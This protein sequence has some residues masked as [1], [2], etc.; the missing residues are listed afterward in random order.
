LPGII[1]FIVE[2]NFKNNENENGHSN[3]THN[4]L[5]NNDVYGF[6]YKVGIISFCLIFIIMVI[7]YFISTNYSFYLSQFAVENE[8]LI[9]LAIATSSIA[10]GFISLFYKFLKKFL[11]FEL[12]FILA[13]LFL[14]SGYTCISL[15][16]TFYI[17]VLGS[18]IM[19]LGWGTFMPNITNWLLKYTPL[20][21]RGRVY[22][23]FTTLAYLGQF[24][25]PIISQPIINACNL[26]SLYLIGG[27]VLYLLLFV[28]V[29]LIISRQIRK[30]TNNNEE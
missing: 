18:A 26:S 23:I 19:G 20:K 6:P 3:N 12:I 8:L 24:F 15:A 28:P 2:R 13:L 22:G 29:G 25:S 14:G 11:T 27:I 7:F 16:P 21:F 1:F 4:S 5:K 10:A 9:G 30:K 17:V